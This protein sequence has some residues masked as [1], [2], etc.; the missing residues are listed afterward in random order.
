[1]F[2]LKPGNVFE[3]I[4]KMNRKQAYTLG[5]IVVVC[6]IAL[7][8]LASFMGDADDESFDAFNARGYDL[9]QM[10]FVSDEAEQYLLASKYPD[11]QNN[12]STALYTAEE[13]EER[14]AEDAAQAGEEYASEESQDYSSESS[15]SDSSYSGSSGRSYGGYR[16]SRG[17]GGGATQV[18]RLDSASMGHASGSGVGGSWGAPRGDFSPYKSQNKGKETPVT[19]LKN[20]DARKALYQ[21]A[22][23]SRAAAGLKEGKL[24][25]AKKAL[26]G[27]TITGGEAFTDNGVDL[28]QASGLDLDTNAPSSSSDFNPSDLNDAV[29]D[30][31]DNSNDKDDDDKETLK[32]RLL[33][34]LY[35]GLIDIGMQ[36]LSN[37]ANMLMEGA[38]DAA[39][40]NSAG[41]EVAQNAV[42][43]YWNIDDVS[44]A[45]DEQLAGMAAISGK[46]VDEL[47]AM[48]GCSG[49]DV[50]KDGGADF[51][52]NQEYDRQQRAAAEAARQQ[53]LE[54]SFIERNESSV[55]LS[56]AFDDNS[57]STE[58]KAVSAKKAARQD[59]REQRDYLDNLRKNNPSVYN[60]LTYNGV[61]VQ[62]AR[63]AAR[64]RE[65]NW[66]AGSN[67]TYSS[68][69]NTQNLSPEEEE[70]NAVR[71]I[72][73]EERRKYEW[74]RYVDGNDYDKA[75]QSY[76]K[77]HSNANE[78]NFLK[79]WNKRHS[80]E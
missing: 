54:D 21:F 72:V 46:S 55:D 8:S 63:E 23:G 43:E 16:G 69:K 22:R 19:Q 65:F 33:E 78:E 9:A 2:K 53:K 67:N 15:Y 44:K 10:P 12:G 70:E 68:L 66:Y 64:G 1:M 24:A 13:K 45:T 18:G 61:S 74:L 3:K 57:G 58:T 60:N 77:T 47:R 80:E 36:V 37:G 7:I 29:N 26:M 75:W 5:A 39:A 14:Q 20:K 31:K 76:K 35:S 6:I 41:N 30:A 79:Y 27:G 49:K 28:S 38:A 56:S 42:N 32:D 62:A 34:Q 4:N 52:K 50:L 71:R 48:G 17:G 59:R 11:M 40:A 51:L 73:A 25:N